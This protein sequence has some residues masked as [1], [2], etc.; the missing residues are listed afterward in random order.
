MYN[1]HKMEGIAV[2]PFSLTVTF[3][4]FPGPV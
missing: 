3:I 1:V 2:H 4:H